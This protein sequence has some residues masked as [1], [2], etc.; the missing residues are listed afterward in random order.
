MTATVSC[1]ATCL[2]MWRVSSIARERSGRDREG[3]R[4]WLIHLKDFGV[5]MDVRF[6]L[7]WL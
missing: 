2:I 7:G 5:S 1:P 4:S 3:Q 6:S